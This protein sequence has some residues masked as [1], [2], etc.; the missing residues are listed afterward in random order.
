VEVFHFATTDI[1]AKMDP[2]RP[3]KD[4]LYLRC[5]ELQVEGRQF[6]DRTT[7]HMIAKYNVEFRTDQYLGYADI[8]KYDES[9]EMVIFEGVNGNTVRIYEIAT[10]GGRPREMNFTSSKVLYNRK[11]GRFFSDGVKSIS[12]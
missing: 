8:V 3:S 6:V 4:Q 12:N 1:N 9:T 10:P 7:Q 5:G 2:D 11:T